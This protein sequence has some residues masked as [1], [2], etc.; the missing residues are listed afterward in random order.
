MKKKTK[1]NTTTT[2]R[3]EQSARDSIEPAWIRILRPGAAALKSNWYSR[4]LYFPS[5]QHPHLHRT[6]AS[7]SLSFHPES[8]GNKLLLLLPTLLMFPFGFESKQMSKC[9]N[10]IYSLLCNMLT[11][12]RNSSGR[13]ESLDVAFI[14]FIRQRCAE[15]SIFIFWPHSCCTIHLY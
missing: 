5:L 10:I 6:A 14:L 7:A 1:K 9:K 4:S 12:W 11:Y 15:Y 13:G 8:C 3:W 2:F